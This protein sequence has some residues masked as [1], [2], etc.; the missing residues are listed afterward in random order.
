MDPM[1]SC[2]SNAAAIRLLVTESPH[3]QIPLHGY[4]TIVLL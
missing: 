4:A 1:G 2:G 3:T